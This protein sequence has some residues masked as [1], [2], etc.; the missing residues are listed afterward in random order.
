[1]SRTFVASLFRDYEVNALKSIRS[2]R[3]RWK[4]HLEEEFAQMRAVSVTTDSI[5]TY[6]EKRQKEG[7][8]NATINRELA[9]LRVGH[10]GSK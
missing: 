5:N 1:M 7:A 3:E 4:N 6:I 8:E 10:S 9:L 2:A